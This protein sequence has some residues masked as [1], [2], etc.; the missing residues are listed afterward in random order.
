MNSIIIVAVKQIR[1]NQFAGRIFRAD[2][3]SKALTKVYK[4]GYT[5][6][7][8]PTTTYNPLYLN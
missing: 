3:A 6:C 5:P 1:P 2:S 7:F 4:A 8:Y